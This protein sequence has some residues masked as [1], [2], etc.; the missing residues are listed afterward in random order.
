MNI[1]KT[2]NAIP[3]TRLISGNK[4]LKFIQSR[5]PPTHHCSNFHCELINNVKHKGISHFYG[6]GEQTTCTENYSQVYLEPIVYLYLNA[7][8]PITAEKDVNLHSLGFHCCK[9]ATLIEWTIFGMF[10]MFLTSSHFKSIN[11][12]GLG[13]SKANESLKKS[14]FE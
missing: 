12:R 11:L 1:S 7:W 8:M 4:I 2:L 10:F 5:K 3:Y 6:F 13:N 9:I 14:M